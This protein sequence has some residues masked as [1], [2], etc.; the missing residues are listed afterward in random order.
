M[1]VFEW[2]CLSGSVWVEV[3]KWKC[4]WKCLSGSV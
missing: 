1:E 4:E 3:F 2:K